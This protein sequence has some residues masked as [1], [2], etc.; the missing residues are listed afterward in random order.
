MLIQFLIGPATR[1]RADIWYTVEAS[2]EAVG[3]SDM[4][5]AL[6]RQP[7]AYAA[8][9]GMRQR[10]LLLEQRASRAKRRGKAECGEDAAIAKAVIVPC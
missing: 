8:M 3:L 9:H 7:A 1:R 5:T 6:D 2:S 10:P 4:Q